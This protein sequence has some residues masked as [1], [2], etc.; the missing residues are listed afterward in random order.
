VQSR[1]VSKNGFQERKLLHPGNISLPLCPYA[2]L[3]EITE[4]KKPLRR[5]P[6]RS[7]RETL[8]LREIFISSVSP[9]NHLYD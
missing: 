8:L 9:T 5:C 7:P 6:P 1:H 4:A 2:S 3:R